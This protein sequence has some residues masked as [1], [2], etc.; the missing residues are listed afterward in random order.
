LATTDMAALLMLELRLTIA[1][2]VVKLPPWIGGSAAPGEA[3]YPTLAG[4]TASS[5]AWPNELPD[6]V[7]VLCLCGARLSFAR[8]G[9]GQER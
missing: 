3:R 6:S 5:G 9:Q 2:P 8:S 1:Q 4:P 7:P